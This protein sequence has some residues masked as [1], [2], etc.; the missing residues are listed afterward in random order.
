MVRNIV[1]AGGSS[2]IGLAIATRFAGSGDAVWVTGR[3]QNKLDRVVAD[4]G[5]TAIRCDHSQPQAIETL[6]PNLPE[7]IDVLVNAV[8]ANTHS[9]APT[10]Q[11]DMHTLARAWHE[12]LAVNLL[13]AVLTT[14]ALL[15]RIAEGG[16][17]IAIGS[18]ATETAATSYG[19]AKAALAAWAAGLSRAI[20]GRGITVNTVTP[21]YTE[22]TEFYP[23]PLPEATTNA[24]IASTHDGRAGTPEDIAGAVFFLTGAEARHITA[25]N[26]H[27]SGGI[28]ITR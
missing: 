28:Y 27:V 24:L 21:N 16:S 3:N 14:T 25:Q 23:T 17:V 7:S 5:V 12:G 15:P 26:L 20:G 6:L 19:A 18:E 4:L 22:G 13:S 8:G 1:V 10:A 11:V 2:G 9:L